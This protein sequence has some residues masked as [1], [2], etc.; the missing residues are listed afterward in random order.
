VTIDELYSIDPKLSATLI[1]VEITPR[2]TAPITDA[3]T[4]DRLA[5]VAGLESIHRIR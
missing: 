4:R 2:W 3:K 1:T 5:D